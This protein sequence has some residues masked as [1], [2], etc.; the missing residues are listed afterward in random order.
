ME[1]FKY[2]IFLF[3]FG[4]LTLF[5]NNS[6]V[7][8]FT[9]EY[10]FNYIGD[11]QEFIVPVNGTY[12]LEVWGAQ[13]AGNHQ[14]SE[15]GYGGKG[16]YSTGELE[17]RK[18]T[19]LYI[20][21]G[22]QG[23]VCYSPYCSVAGGYNGGGSA[24][25]KTGGSGDP[26]ASG[27]GA[28]DIR[29]IGGLWND[30]KSL[31]SRFIV[32]GAGGGGGMDGNTPNVGAERGGDGGGLSGIVYDNETG[33][34]GT[35]DSGW[36]F[37][38]GF[39]ANSKNNA[40][41]S[42]TYG[43][44]GGGSGWYGGSFA[45]NG[46]WQGAGGG[47]GFVLTRDSA[48]KVPNGYSVT[49]EYYLKNALT[50][51]GNELIPTHNHETTMKGNSGNGFAKITILEYDALQIADLSLN[52][53]NT[54][55]YE[56]IIPNEEFETTISYNNPSVIWSSGTGK[57][58]LKVDTIHEV[59]LMD[60]NGSINV[61]NIK[62]LSSKVYLDNVIFDGIDFKF[63]KQRYLYE[64]NVSNEIN[65]INPNI[66]VSDDVTYKINKT[67]LN[68]GKNI[69]EITALKDG[70]TSSTYTFVINREYA[71]TLRSEEH[72]SELQSQR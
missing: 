57:V 43:G 35:Q 63:D 34:G 64:F 27:G 1:K 54:G 59:I 9:T 36:K 4:I 55:N 67:T 26:A 15:L 13:G 37:G 51:A 50:Q 48:T 16:G 56:V 60:D 42:N 40:Y 14:H 71:K 66:V 69:I 17:L 5:N 19:K 61:Y 8:A 38:E 23:N 45:R 39:S 58:T 65:E 49:S 47:S 11:V 12:K 62:V 31:L 70:F 24:W 41:I 52:Y 33:H 6:V 53:L 30:K 32:A 25:K 18:G 3:L 2:I 44:A 28:T 21:V 72:T 68:V 29:L 20:Y 22:G 46:G 7:E 10:E